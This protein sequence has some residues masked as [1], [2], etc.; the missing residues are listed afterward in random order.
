MLTPLD[1]ITPISLATLWSR[2][3]ELL[4]LS[5]SVALSVIAGSNMLK[6]LLLLSVC[7]TLPHTAFAGPIVTFEAFGAVTRSNSFFPP[8]PIGPFPDGIPQAPPI[9]T[10]YAIQ[11]MFDPSA[12]VPTPG[13]PAGGP[14]HTTS[15]TGSFSLG[16]ASYGLTGGVY[17][18]AFLPESNCYSG[19]L[20]PPGGIEFFLGTIADGGDP[21]YLNQGP[22]F[23]DLLY[24]DGLH[25]DGTLPTTPTI[26]GPFNELLFRNELFSFGGSFVP[27]AVVEQPTPV[28]EPGTMALVGIGLA[29]A[30]RQ[31]RRRAGSR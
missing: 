24:F 1:T 4:Q 30:A 27:R 6:K 13:A 18:N 8:I 11:L 26:T 25:Q 28:P 3:A 20:Q 12:R 21:W 17:T 5:A 22:R 10:P 16:G 14:C 15:V 29:L 23:L 2:V 7:L 19:P 9:G 31:R